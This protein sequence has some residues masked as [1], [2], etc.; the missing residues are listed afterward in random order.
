MKDI[1]IRKN[2]RFYTA[3]GQRKSAFLADPEWRTTSKAARSQ[4]YLDTLLEI[5]VDC[6]TLLEYVDRLLQSKSLPR[7]YCEARKLLYHC[8]LVEEM[9][10][11][12]YGDV[13]QQAPEWSSPKSDLH[14]LSLLASSNSAS[15]EFNVSEPLQFS[16]FKVAQAH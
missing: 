7:P 14:L 2:L 10:L 3:V 5:L 9:L 12:W 16:S 13:F 1:F 8:L 15:L 11:K 4:D 6:T